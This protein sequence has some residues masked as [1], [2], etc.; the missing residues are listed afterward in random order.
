MTVIWKFKDVKTFIS[1]FFQHLRHF[2]GIQS[3]MGRPLCDII[4][5]YDYIKRPLHLKR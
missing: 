2:E 3:E 5:L 1:L 4:T